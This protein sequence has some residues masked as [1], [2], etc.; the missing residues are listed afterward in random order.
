MSELVVTIL[1]IANTMGGKLQVLQA[2]I[3][4]HYVTSTTTTMIKVTFYRQRMRLNVVM[5]YKLTICGVIP[6]A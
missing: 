1:Q 3:D 5:Q 4:S 6:E 2:S